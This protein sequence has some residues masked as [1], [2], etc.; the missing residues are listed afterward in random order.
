MEVAK[1]AP[2]LEA[3]YQR[4]PVPVAVKFDNVAPVQKVCDAAPVGAGEDA[5]V[6]EKG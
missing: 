4:I 1:G 2:P 5:I 6:T 3:A